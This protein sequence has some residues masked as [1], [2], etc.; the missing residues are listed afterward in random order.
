MWKSSSL[1]PCFSHTTKRP[2]TGSSTQLLWVMNYYV[3]QDYLENYSTLSRRMKTLILK[4]GTDSKNFQKE[5]GNKDRGKFFGRGVHAPPKYKNIKLFFFFLYLFPYY[6][7][8]LIYYFWKFIRGRGHIP[9]YSNGEN[10][11][12]I[13]LLGGLYFVLL[14][15]RFLGLWTGTM[16]M[17]YFINKSR[18]YLFIN[19]LFAKRIMSWA[20]NNEETI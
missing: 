15:F 9:W 14:E 5:R 18:V 13:A 6:L 4:S 16:S 1:V 12:F 8:N 10:F 11:K 19:S 3:A 20:G 2:Q 7:F 17:K